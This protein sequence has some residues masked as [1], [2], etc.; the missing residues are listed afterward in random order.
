M[1]ITPTVGKLPVKF[2]HEPPK[3]VETNIPTSVATYTSFG[4]LLG[5]AKLLCGTSGSWPLS[6]SCQVKQPS[7][8][9]YTCDLPKLPTVA[10]TRSALV[11][12]VIRHEILKFGNSA[13]ERS[14][15]QVSPPSR[16]R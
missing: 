3:S 12:L 9:W 6:M 5:I 14:P 13:L 8:L 2:F 1:S 10:M 11:G 16:L 4:R 7:W 15:L